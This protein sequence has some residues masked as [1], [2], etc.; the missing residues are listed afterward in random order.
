MTK[1]LIGRI[2]R[3]FAAI[4]ADH[5]FLFRVYGITESEFRVDFPDAASSLDFLAGKIVFCGRVSHAESV[6]ALRRADY[7]VFIREATRKNT[8]GFPT[9]F[10]ECVTSGVGVIVNRISNIADYFPLENGFLL[11]SPDEKSIQTA[12]TAAIEKGKTE[13]KAKDTF[14]YRG[15]VSDFGKFLEEL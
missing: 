10:A 8:A 11:D 7:C 13:H 3:C 15:Y 6:Y 4:A 5:D 12:L 14:D 9:K 2:V 1:D